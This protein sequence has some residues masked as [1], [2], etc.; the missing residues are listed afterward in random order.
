MLYKIKY[1]MIE[2][3]KMVNFFKMKIKVSEHR[4]L[5]LSQLLGIR[6]IKNIEEYQLEK[7]T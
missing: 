5:N 7:Y 6:L 1:Q 4:E 2:K 3:I